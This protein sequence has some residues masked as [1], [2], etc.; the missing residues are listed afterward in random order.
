[1]ERHIIPRMLDPAGKYSLTFARI[2]LGLI[3]FVHGLAN[4]FGM[5]G[6]PGVH[7]FAEDMATYVSTSP[8][9]LAQIIA[10]GQ[11]VLGL[12]L[13]L[14]LFSSIASIV[15]LTLIVLAL[16]VSGRYQKFYVRDNGCEYLLALAALS[17]I[18]AVHGPGALALDI[19]KLKKL[20]R[21]E[22]KEA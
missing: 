3:V 16:L 9:L 14:G 19:K 4:S 7:K 8:E 20:L 1:M 6:G 2:V 12:L 21:K 15:V 17:M 22:K 11:V 10:Y 13:M 5:F 18:V